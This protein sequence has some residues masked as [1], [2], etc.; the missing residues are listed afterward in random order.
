MLILLVSILVFPTVRAVAQSRTEE[1]QNVAIFSM[2]ST[3]D[4]APLIKQAFTAMNQPGLLD[5]LEEF[6]KTQREVFATLD[7]SKPKGI[8][9]QTN[10]RS[11]R[12]LAFVAM[13]DVTK[14]PYDIGEKVADCEVTR[15]GWYKMPLPNA[16]QLPVMFKNVFV[17]QQGDWAYACY[18]AVQPPAQL[19]TDAS[20]LLEGLDNE[21]PVALRFNCAAMPRSLVNGYA[22]LG[23]AS[24]P[25]LK[26]F[27]KMAN[28]EDEYWVPI[29][30]SFAVFAKETIDLLVKYI[31]ETESVT[32][33]LSGNADSDLIITCQL[34]AKPDT[35]VAEDLRKIANSTTDLIG[36]YRPDDAFYTE[37]YALP[38]PVY[39]QTYF[40]NILIAA[41]KWMVNTF[42]AVLKDREQYLEP[43]EIAVIKKIFTPL[44]I[45]PDVLSQTID[46]GKIDI[47]D[48]VTTDMT[49]FLAMK[50]VGGNALVKPI[51]ELYDFGLIKMAEQLAD[52]GFE[53]DISL[54]R[55]TWKGFHFWKA[56]LDD[57]QPPG[58]VTAI[59]GI[60]DEM[61]VFAYGLSPTAMETLK[62]AI[63]RSGQPGPAPKEIVVYS[64][65]RIAS[66]F[67][68]LG[69]DLFADES[70][71]T[72]VILD[73]ADNIPENAKIVVTQEAEGNTLTY[74]A[75]YDGTLWPTVGA[76]LNQWPVISGQ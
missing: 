29:F 2:I 24:I 23:K 45:I 66:M 51:N 48:F 32:F 1:W 6:E 9:C 35:D 62:D 19:P 69:L 33:G 5:T 60:S 38:I 61:F 55:E 25:M 30:D 11:F 75:V 58:P 22:A 76:M 42:N 53:S 7:F 64:A 70:T 36:F 59:I 65:G 56:F 54:E 40:K 52:Y 20:V 72:Q 39:E 73:I 43:D 50:I 47:A 68:S 8:V 3:D 21:Y 67:K 26:M 16:D 31:H 49:V 10:G 41:D 37:L 18:G 44:K 74:K 4:G 57:Q 14:L 13:E 34:V 15:D 28:V 46:T 71:E 17:K 63:D 12:F 27:L